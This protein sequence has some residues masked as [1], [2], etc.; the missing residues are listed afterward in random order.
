MPLAS[1]DRREVGV[2]TSQAWEQLELP[3]IARGG[4]LVNLCN[5]APLSHRRSVTLIHDAQVFLSPQSYSRAFRAWYRF[6][7]PRIGA[8]AAHVVTVSNYS[9]E[10]LI[11]FGV[12]PAEKISVVHNGVDHFRT[13]A[14]KGDVVARLALTPHRYVVAAAGV[15]KHKN[16]GVLFEAF[17][18]PGLADL[19]LVVV[20]GDDAAAFNAA[21]YTP[22]PGVVFAGRM[23][24]GELKALYEQAACLAFPSTT[25]GFGLP[26]LEAMSLGCPVVAAPCGALPEVCGDA[27]LYANPYD[28]A[29]WVQAIRL[30]ADDGEA[31]TRLVRIGPS[32][33]GCY[34]WEDSA[35]RLLDIVW[36]AA[37]GPAPLGRRSAP[38]V[39]GGDDQNHP[40]A[41][42][43]HAA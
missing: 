31:R 5:L 30:A 25:E 27:V 34:R 29:A 10:R 19:T 33:A 6:A 3:W 41:D 4:V 18:S 12:A 20:G 24:D 36:K 1:I 39:D 13:V 15:Q 2:L 35:R 23:S 16:L 8:G 22:G 43:E 42:G 9:R 40:A 11:E 32:R 37:Q 28:P 26:P 38:D 17:K 7:L 21:G 14:A